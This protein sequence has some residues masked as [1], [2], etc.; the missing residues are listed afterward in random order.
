M[1]D[2]VDRASAREAEI[3]ADALAAQARRAG[4]TGKTPADSAHHCAECDEEIPAVRRRAVPGCQLCVTCR[5]RVE[6]L[7]R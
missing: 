6:R 2:D 7:N 1:S 5:E 4:L 3:L